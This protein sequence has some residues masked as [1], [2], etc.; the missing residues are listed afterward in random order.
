MSENFP[1]KSDTPRVPHMNTKIKGIIIRYVISPAAARSVPS[2][3]LS[4]LIFPKTLKTRK[5]RNIRNVRSELRPST[6][7][8]P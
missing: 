3:T 4:D 5:T 6:F 7:D 2:N 8:N 1:E